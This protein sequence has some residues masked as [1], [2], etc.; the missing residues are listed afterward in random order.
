MFPPSAESASCCK[1][2]LTKVAGQVVARFGQATCAPPYRDAGRAITL[3]HPLHAVTAMN[4]L[5]TSRAAG[6]TRARAPVPALASIL[7]VDDKPARL[8]TYEAILSGLEVNCVRAQ[9]GTEALEKLLSQDFAV[10]LL[11]VHTPD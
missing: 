3:R 10:I 8:L 6:S 4:D 1:K 9:S 2:F 11:D 5:L 7:L